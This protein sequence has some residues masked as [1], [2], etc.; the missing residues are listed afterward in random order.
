MARNIINQRYQLLP[1]LYSLQRMASTNGSPVVAPL[2][3][4]YPQDSNTYSQDQEFLLG[5]YLL[6]APMTVEGATSRDVYLPAGADW[7]D[8]QTGVSYPGAQQITVAAPLDRIPVFAREG[9]IIPQGPIKQFVEQA[10]TPGLSIDIYPGPD[11]QFT[12]YEDDGTSFDYQNGSYLNTLVK[13]SNNSQGSSISI[14]RIAGTWSPAPRS[15]TL[16]LHGTTQ[17]SGVSL[18]GT[19]LP[20]AVNLQALVSASSG[21]IFD[22]AAQLVA[23]KIQDSTQAATVFVQP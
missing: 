14:Q 1:Y 22:P 10:V 23:V 19:A 2:L 4:Y 12:M 17:A 7:T 11:S 3:F 13:R 5:P 20:Q 8:V 18:N 6:I 16:L 9:A 21:W 15:I